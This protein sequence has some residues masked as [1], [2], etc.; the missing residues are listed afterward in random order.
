MKGFIIAGLMLIVDAF[1][2]SFD[3]ENGGNVGFNNSEIALPQV[4]ISGDLSIRKDITLMVFMN[5]KND[6]SDSS[7]LGIVGK[8]AEKDLDEMKKIGTTEKVNIVVEIGEKGKGSRRLVVLKKDLFSSGERVYGKY[9]DADMGDYNR[10][11]DFV[12]WSR[13]NFPAR[14]YIL[15]LWNHGLGWID[16]VLKKSTTPARLMEKGISFD[17]ETKNYIRTAQLK[18][19]FKRIGYIDV[20]VFN[21]CLMQMAEVDYEFK[22]YTSL[23]IGSEETMLAYGFDYERFIKFLNQKTDFTKKEIADFFVNWY[24]DFYRDG[25]NIGPLNIPLKNIAATLSAVDG[26][27]L[28][29]LPLYLNK[30]ALTVMENNEKSAVKSAIG[31][32]IRFTGLDPRDKEKKLAP[33][34]DLYDFVKKVSD[35]AKEQST[36]E[37]AKVLLDFIKNNLV[38]SSIGL[39]KDETN[40]Y[41][42]SQAGGVSINMTMKIKPLPPQFD[43]LLETK[44]PDLSLSKDSLWD[45]FVEWCNRVYL[46]N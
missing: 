13:E 26:D 34:V 29:N 30:F 19:M 14:R 5:A 1:S 25:I 7:L 16:P 42:Y 22:D 6:L 18:E 43:S 37:S 38:I 28:K 44:Y 3:F 11:V 4:N 46:E 20:V 24:R 12:K 27:E 31:S 32:V 23:I 41:D 35:N 17:E 40:N 9:P 39:N 15:V 45:E 21:A 33:Y 2:F 10:V 8:W 36:K